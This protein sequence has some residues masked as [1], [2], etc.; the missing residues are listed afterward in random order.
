MK[1]KEKLIE[2]CGTNS[3]YYG[4]APMI[5]LR[6]LERFE[7]HVNVAIQARERSSVGHTLSAL[8]IEEKTWLLGFLWGLLGG[9]VIFM[10]ELD[11]FS[12]ELEDIWNGIEG[13]EEE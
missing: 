6:L 10:K 3:F 1:F 8:A 7:T 13:G 4:T 2:L 11:V 12:Q 5:A 9:G